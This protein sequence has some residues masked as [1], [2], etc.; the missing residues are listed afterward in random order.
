MSEKFNSDSPHD[1]PKKAIENKKPKD[2]PFKIYDDGNRVDPSEIVEEGFVDMARVTV[3]ST[4]GELALVDG[5]PRMA[6]VKCLTRCHFLVL[7][8]S[9]YVKALKDQERKK[10]YEKV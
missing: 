10:K 7:N 1:S 4:L 8:R 2:D 3:G 5:K 9:D 6:T